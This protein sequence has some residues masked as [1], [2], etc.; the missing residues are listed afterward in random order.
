MDQACGIRE[1]TGSRV[2]PRF[3]NEPL[4]ELSFPNMEPPGKGA[5]H[6]HP[7]GMSGKDMVRH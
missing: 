5:G 4:V 7:M 1:I 6:G 3:L 2:S